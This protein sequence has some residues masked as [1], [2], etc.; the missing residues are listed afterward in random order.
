LTLSET[1]PISYIVKLNIKT[2]NILAIRLNKLI[3]II[4]KVDYHNF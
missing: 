2:I 3:I 1:S 4:I